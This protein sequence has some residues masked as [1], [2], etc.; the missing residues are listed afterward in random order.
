[1]KKGWTLR[2]LRGGSFNNNAGNC[3]PA[4]RNNNNPGNTNNNNGFR[5]V[6]APGLASAAAWEWRGRAFGSPDPF[7]RHPLGCPKI[8]SGKVDMV[9]SI[10]EVSTL[11]RFISLRPSGIEHWM[12]GRL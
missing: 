1:M 2:V 10:P 3:R 12:G 7:L 11:P 9:G 5:V 8:Q 6:R 4:N